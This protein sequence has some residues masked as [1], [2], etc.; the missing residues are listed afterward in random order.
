MIEWA[1]KYPA[2]I[3][4]LV[5][6]VQWSMAVDTALAVDFSGETKS[7]PIYELKTVLGLLGTK[8]S[9][10]AETVLNVKVAPTH[11]RNMSKLSLNLYISA[12]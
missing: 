10:M 12:M 5:S 4:P 6:L 8:L 2:Q 7:I 3:V 1:E 9:V 11:V